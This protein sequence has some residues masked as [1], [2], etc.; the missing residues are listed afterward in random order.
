MS[1][2]SFHDESAKHFDPTIPNVLPH[3]KMYKLQVGDKL[4]ILSGASLSSDA[5]S[6]F[7]NYF[8]N[9]DEDKPLFLDRSPDVFNYI[10]QHLQGYHVEI[11]NCDVFTKLFSDS[12]YFN[13]PRLKE[14]LQKDDYYHVEM[15]NE[16]VKVPKKLLLTEGNY[17]NFF[18]VTFEALYRDLSELMISKNLIRPPPQAAPRLNRDGGLLKDLIKLLQG[19]DIPFQCQDHKRLLIKEAK[20][21]RFN[22]IVE[23]LG[24]EH[25]FQSLDEKDKGKE[26]IVVDLNDINPRNFVKKVEENLRIDEDEDD[27]EK[28]HK[29]QKTESNIYE[30]QRKYGIDPYSRAIIIKIDEL[31]GVEFFTNKPESD[32]GYTIYGATFQNQVRIKLLKFLK[33]LFQHSKLSKININGREFDFDQVFSFTIMNKII[34]SKIDNGDDDFFKSKEVDLRLYDENNQVQPIKFTEGNNKDIKS[35]DYLLKTS[36]WKLIIKEENHD[37]LDID[38]ELVKAKAVES[39]NAEVYNAFLR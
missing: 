23:K 37:T 26:Y 12:I 38:F 32:D 7:T 28:S 21:Y 10:Y 6:Y 9:N 24:Y 29:R 11:P 15:I 17:P 3:G 8:L 1:F 5:P 36:Y 20:Y 35:I 22:T 30:Y 2:L 27:E 34:F 14:L 19:I 16:H 33:T 25:I 13:L 4:F 31:N 39:N 18:S